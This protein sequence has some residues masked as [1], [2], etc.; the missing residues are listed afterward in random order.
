MLVIAIDHGASFDRHLDNW[1]IDHAQSDGVRTRIGL[2]ALEG[3][4][5]EALVLSAELISSTNDGQFPSCWL[6]LP[7]QNIKELP[8]TLATAVD[9]A[10]MYHH[11]ITAIKTGVR[12]LTTRDDVVHERAVIALMDARRQLPDVRLVVEP[13]FADDDDIRARVDTVAALD[14]ACPDMYYKMDFW[15]GNPQWLEFLAELLPR[16]W[17]LR[18]AGMTFASF[19]HAL[20]VAMEHGCDG[21][22]VGTAVW[23]DVG[24]GLWAG[25]RNAQL[26]LAERLQQLTK[27][28]AT[29]GR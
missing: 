5:I 17:A 19:A 9:V 24:G 4:D 14:R 2:D 3:G 6:G 25:E 23:A 11:R 28:I 21:A 22:I 10:E 12:G 16:R 18:S 7:D 1:G 29:A 8:D 26:T 15:Q 20:A 27:A 13:Y